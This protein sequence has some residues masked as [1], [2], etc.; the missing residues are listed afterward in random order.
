MRIRVVSSELL[1]L[2][3]Q[4]RQA[5]LSLDETRLLIQR[6]WS[7]LDWEVRQDVALEALVIQAQ[8]QALA[9]MEE[10]ERLGQFL[11]ERAAA[12]DQADTDGAARLSQTSGAWLASIGGSA[13]LRSDG[14]TSFPTARAQGYLR[15]GGWLDGDEA[16]LASLRPVRIE[17]QEQRALFDFALDEIVSKVGPLGLLKDGWDALHIPTW[18]AQVQHASVV[19][20]N[21]RLHYGANAPQT[22]AAYGNYLETMIFKM[23]FFGTKAEALISLLKIVGRMNPV[24]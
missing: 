12:F 19:W 8:R 18:Q 15:L 23:P 17:P 2:S 1:T 3:M 6:A 5:A 10:A 4:W 9:L 24:E 20:G 7:S 22:Q 13:A 11:E 14:L 16:S 21:A